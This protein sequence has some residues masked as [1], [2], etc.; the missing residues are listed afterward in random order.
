MKAQLSFCR[1]HSEGKK[2]E[3]EKL[4]KGLRVMRKQL[5]S[6]VLACADRFTEV[7]W[8]RIVFG[9]RYSDGSMQCH[10]QSRKSAGTHPL[11]VYYK[12]TKKNEQNKL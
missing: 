8:F 3:R 5:Q 1:C 10:G 12:Q 6:L 7:S 9:P 11:S 4:V 2:K